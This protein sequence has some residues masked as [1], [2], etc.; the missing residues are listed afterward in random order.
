[1]AFE[2]DNH[3]THFKIFA[4]L[5]QPQNFKV[6]ANE[7]VLEIVSFIDILISQQ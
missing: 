2:V 5:K 3:R 4:I 1:M 7:V 6:F